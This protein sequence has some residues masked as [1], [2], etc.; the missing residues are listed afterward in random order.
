MTETESIVNQ[1]N[2]ELLCIILDMSCNS[3]R[4]DSGE[5]RDAK[6]LS[7]VVQ[8]IGVLTRAHQLL[9]TTNDVALVVTLPEKRFLFLIFV[10]MACVISTRTHHLF[11]VN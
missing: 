2:N 1:T 10:I 8:C 7:H 5:N 4:R 3:W 11:I 6:L 9:S